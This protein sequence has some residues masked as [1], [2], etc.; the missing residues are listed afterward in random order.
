MRKQYHFRESNEELL[1]WDVHKLIGLTKDLDAE[2]VQ[3]AA[4]REL[5]D[6][7]WYTSEDDSPTCRS[8]AGHMRLV[9][10]ADLRWP[11]IICPEG[12]VM[13]GMHRVVKALLEGR[14]TIRAFRLPTLPA[15]DYVGIDPEDLPYDDG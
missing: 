10:A 1:A 3:L 8:I 5:D 14:G 12:R 11:I 7:Y 15:P 9:Q 13:D 4:I 6:P 2:D